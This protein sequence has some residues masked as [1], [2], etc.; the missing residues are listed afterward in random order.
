MININGIR[1]SYGDAEILKGID[2]EV[3]DG[4]V[5]VIIG[6][7]GSGKSTFLR[8]LNYLETPDAGTIKVDDF[9]IDAK[10]YTK[11]NVKELR[12]KSA[13]VFQNFNLFNNRTVLENV[14]EGHITVKKMSKRESEE[15]ALSLLKK[16]NMDMKKDSYPKNLSGGQKQRVSIARAIAMNPEFI[17]FDEPTSALDPE[18]VLD[19][20]NLI[21]DLAKENRT[22][23]IVTHEIS[24]AKDVADVIVFMDE[25]IIIE[26]GSTDEVLLN[27]KESRTKEFLSNVHFK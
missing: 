8:C 16:V 15:T 3:K 2:L 14:M 7:S 26:K 4:E 19:V 10:N 23:I 11:N 6:P 5:I 12:S 25:G 9:K 18:M 20:L 22:M 24:F 1:K 21:K 13:M 17:L 27:P